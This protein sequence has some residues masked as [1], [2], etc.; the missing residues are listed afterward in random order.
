MRLLHR[1]AVSELGSPHMLAQIVAAQRVYR[2]S[3]MPD[4]RIFVAEAATRDLGSGRDCIP[5]CFA[6]VIDRKRRGKPAHGG[7]RHP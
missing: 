3:E 1:S 2:L 7:K 5:A 6:A 4:A